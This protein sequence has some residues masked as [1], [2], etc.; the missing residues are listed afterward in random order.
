MNGFEA[1]AAAI[2]VLAHVFG[3]QQLAFQIVRP[4]VIRANQNAHRA[5]V[6]VAQT[7]TA[8]AADG[9]KSLD[10][11]VGVAHEDEGIFVLGDW[12]VVAGFREFGRSGKD[13][14]EIQSIM[15]LYVDAYLL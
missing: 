6:F 4:L 12:Y 13:T 7:R 9:V 10:F 8:M 11:A 5:G 15:R 3:K 14:P 1:I 2:E